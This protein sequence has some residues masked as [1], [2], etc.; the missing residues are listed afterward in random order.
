MRQIPKIIHLCW[1][2][3]DPYPENIDRCIRSW[4]EFLPDYEI[5]LWDNIRFEQQI[6][7]NYA[8]EA[9][10]NKK[11]AF[12]AD[13][14]RLFALYKFGGIYLDSDVRVYKSFDGFL[15][16]SFFS[17]IEYFKPTNYIAIEAAVMGAVSNHPFIK[18][19]L[20]LYDSISFIGSDGKMD[21][22]TITSRI[23]QIAEQ[24]WGFKYEPIQQNL[25]DGMKIYSPVTFTNP[26]GEFSLEKTY[27]LHLCNGSWVDNKP[28]LLLRG[29]RF[30][31]RYYSNPIIALENIYKKI[32]SVIFR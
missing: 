2:S 16:N 31:K 4:K 18:E 9:L 6:N 3:G 28:S 8:M 14:V 23:A 20:M 24:N 7:S 15:D 25:K 27:A 17:C 21:K 5:M 30:I 22:T 29:F 32:K 13:Y 26:S 12:V 10:K 19:C 11:W 1:I